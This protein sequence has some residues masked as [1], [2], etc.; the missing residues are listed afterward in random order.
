[1]LSTTPVRPLEIDYTVSRYGFEVTSFCRISI[2]YMRDD[3][4][5][6]DQNLGSKQTGHRFHHEPW[7]S[8]HLFSQY[9]NSPNTF[10]SQDSSR[11]RYVMT[12]L[13][14]FPSRVS[15]HEIN[16]SIN[17][18]PRGHRIKRVLRATI[19]T[20]TAVVLVLNIV[21]IRHLPLLNMWP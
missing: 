17:R 3:T 14:I 5:V 8:G 4:H 19:V 18:H 11:T 10:H 12:A 20:L 13:L 15:I 7:K 6:K 1:M 2:L 21:R 9:V 16:R